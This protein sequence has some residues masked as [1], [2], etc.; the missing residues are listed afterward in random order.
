VRGQHDGWHVSGAGTAT[1]AGCDHDGQHGGRGQAR[2][3]RGAAGEG[4]TGRRCV[5]GRTGR[6]EMICFAD[7]WVPLICRP[8]F[9]RP[10]GVGL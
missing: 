10:A 7:M 9:E 1:G 4:E 5:L 2:G 3:G 6:E 8:R